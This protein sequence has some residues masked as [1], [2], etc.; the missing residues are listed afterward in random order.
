MLQIKVVCATIAFGMGID[1]PNVRFVIHAALP[2]SIEGYYQESG[3]AGRD[4]EIADCILFYNYSDMHRL[5]R[6][7][8]MDRPP[9]AV[10]KTH[11]DNL[12]KM[13]AFCENKTD[14]RRSQQLNYFGEIFER[15]KCLANKTT[16]CDNCRNK[17]QF[18]VIDVTQDAREIIRAVQE[19]TNGRRVR[20]TLLYLTDIFKGCDLKK[21]RDAGKFLHFSK[22]FLHSHH[23]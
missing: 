8:E 22:F 5:R 20:L 13:V 17:G 21:I 19:I 23:G 1:K 7:L 16:A 15:E 4:G 9:Q 6:M 10:L 14:C 11:M 12:F 2:K 3:R 18:M